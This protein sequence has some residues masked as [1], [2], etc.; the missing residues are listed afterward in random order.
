MGGVGGMDNDSL[1]P[2][3]S[4]AQ[5]IVQAISSVSDR[6]MTL[7]GIYSF[8]QKN[9]PYYRTA[10]RGWQVIVLL[11]LFRSLELCNIFF[12]LQYSDL[13]PNIVSGVARNVNL[14]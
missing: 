9:Y 14:S 11:L 2:P 5:L 1:K 7:S 13:L 10:D 12:L 4:Y 6:Q 3:Y 8:I